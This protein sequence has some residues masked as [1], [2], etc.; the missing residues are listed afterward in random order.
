MVKILTETQ[1]WLSLMLLPLLFVT[2][3]NLGI[4]LVSLGDFLFVFT[5]RQDPL[6][7]ASEMFN[8]FL[9]KAQQVGNSD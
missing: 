9:R 7:G 2:K 5:V 6:L 4:E 8:G 3:F 1:T